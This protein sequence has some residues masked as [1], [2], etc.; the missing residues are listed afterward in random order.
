MANKPTL[1][2]IVMELS[3]DIR[4]DVINLT[5]SFLYYGKVSLY[6]AIGLYAI[7]T[8]GRVIMEN[9]NMKRDFF[10][11]SYSVALGIGSGFSGGL[12]ASQVMYSLREDASPT[13]VMACLLFPIATNTISYL[14][15][16]N[17]KIHHQLTDEYAKKEKASKT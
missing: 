1:G 15:E 16:K 17:R 7:P 3:K 6:T 14:Y 12:L 10:S 11:P 4:G 9:D 13:I 5:E 2:E 8:V